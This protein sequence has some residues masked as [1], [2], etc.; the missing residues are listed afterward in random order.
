M[1]PA[2]IR[3]ARADKSGRARDIARS[4]GLAEAQLVASEV[5]LSAVALEAHPNKLIPAMEPLGR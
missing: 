5:G 2:E 1:T 3:D 4:L